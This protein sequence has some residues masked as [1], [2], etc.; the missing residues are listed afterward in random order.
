M[1]PPPSRPRGPEDGLPRGGMEITA[2]DDGVRY[3]LQVRL[4]ETRRIW[5]VI[6]CHDHGDTTLGLKQGA[7]R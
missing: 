3:E 4:R 5:L 1:G 6:W 2:E 7:A